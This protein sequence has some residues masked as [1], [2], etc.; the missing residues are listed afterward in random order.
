MRLFAVELRRLNAR[1]AFRLLALAA[2][3]LLTVL[4]GATAWDSQPPTEQELQRAQEQV[5]IIEQQKERDVARCEDNPAEFGIS[6]AA[7]CEA[8]LVGGWT[9]TVEDFAYTNVF[10]F[11]D[12]ILFLL[13]PIG[14]LALLLAYIIGVSFVGAEWSSGMMATH[15]TWEPRRGRVLTAKTLAATFVVVVLTAALLALAIGSLYWVAAT[16]GTTDRTTD[17]LLADVVLRALRITGLAAA[18]A[19]VGAAVAGVLRSTVGALVAAGVYIG[20]A[21][22]MLR[23]IWPGSDRWLLSHNTLALLED[24]HVVRR[25]DCSGIGDC[26]QIVTHISLAAGAAV[27]GAVVIVGVLLHAVTF[28]RRDVV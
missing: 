5:E 25:W 3:A 7:E 15:L 13:I 12:E 4:V 14:A 24:G 8:Q 28:Q 17:E 10:S 22:G 26:S 1:R 11:A 23:A 19:A 18:F 21:E 6:E 27:L 9:P 2:V 20:V 16:W